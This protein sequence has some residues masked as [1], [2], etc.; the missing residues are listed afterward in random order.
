MSDTSLRTKIAW[1][2][3]KELYFNKKNIRSAA[4]YKFSPYF[5]FKKKQIRQCVKWYFANRLKVHK[6]G[7][8]NFSTQLI[9]LTCSSNLQV[10]LFAKKNFLIGRIPW[11]QDK[12]LGPI[13][14]YTYL[15]F[16]VRQSCQN[17]IRL[18]SPLVL[19]V[20]D[21][22]NFREEILENLIL[23]HFIAIISLL[24]I[25]PLIC[26]PNIQ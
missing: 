23:Y 4:M 11:R 20:L 25:R 17:T 12:L 2:V 21:M 3:K 15:S 5:V 18:S 9:I 1:C 7:T 6:L 13:F 8:W 10:W 19:S 14:A 26:D 24:W 22:G 16:S